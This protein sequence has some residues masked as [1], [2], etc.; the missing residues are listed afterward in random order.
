M[1]EGGANCADPYAARLAVG[2]A[3]REANSASSWGGDAGLGWLQLDVG[4]TAHD[5][6]SAT[7][8]AIS[9]NIRALRM[10]YTLRTETPSPAAQHT[11][12]YV[13]VLAPE[14]PP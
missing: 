5:F 12:H 9:P 14:T 1:P 4:N 2:N 7:Q 3:T 11:G 6:K 8:S 10:F 13:L